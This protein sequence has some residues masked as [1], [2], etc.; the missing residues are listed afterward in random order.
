MASDLKRVQMLF[1][2][3]ELAEIDSIASTHGLTRT[4][5]VRLAVSA[6]CRSVVPTGTTGTSLMKVDDIE[7]EPVAADVPV[8]TTSSGEPAA[9]AAPPPPPVEPESPWRRLGMAAPAKQ[10]RSTPVNVPDLARPAYRSEA[11][12]AAAERIARQK[13]K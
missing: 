7:P 8:G 5:A 6:M 12:K 2:D 3:E 4:G 11:H 9:E 13:G 1:T 10:L